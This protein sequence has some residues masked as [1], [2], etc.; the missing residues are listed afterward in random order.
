ME[1]LIA[2]IKQ[3]MVDGR[4]L[5]FSVYA[6]AKEQRILNVPVIKPL[7]IFVLS[8]N[9]RLGDPADLSGHGS[10]S[11]EHFCG[12]GQFVFLSNTPTIAMRNIPNDEPYFALLLSFEYSDFA[13]F[14]PISHRTNHFFQGDI[15]LPLEQSLEQLIHWSAF[16]APELWHLRRKE[17][18]HLLVSLGFEQEVRSVMEPPTLSHQVYTLCAADIA[19]DL[20]AQTVA[21]ELAMS[22]STLRRKLLAEGSGFQDIKESVKLGH[23]LHLLQ[24]T[25]DSIGRVA[26]QCG[27]GSQSRF[28]EKFKQRFGLTPRALRK[29]RMIDLG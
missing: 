11:Y 29:T 28:T 17:L 10:N 26:E 2:T 25:F 8:G 7:L 21:A 27:Y 4:P 16:A 13:E 22:E 1:S 12:A 15:S 9:K 5:P 24:T 18:L 19:A 3:A 20:S 6:S 23:G 14:S